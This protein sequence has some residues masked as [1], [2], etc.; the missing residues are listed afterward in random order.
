MESYTGVILVKQQNVGSKSE[1]FYTY[2]VSERMDTI[3]RLYRKDVYSANDSYLM[4]F[5]RKDVSVYGEVQ[6]ETWLM[7]ESIEELNELRIDN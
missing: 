1:G 4:S 7:V 2:L 3:Y 5:D 6:Q